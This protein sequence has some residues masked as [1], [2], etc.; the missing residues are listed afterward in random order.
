MD[1]PP[2]YKIFTC[3]FYKEDFFKIVWGSV[4]KLKYLLYSLFVIFLLSALNACS[5]SNTK[6]AGDKKV[7]DY[8]SDGSVASLSV[9]PD[10][11]LPEEKTDVDIAALIKKNS[12]ENVAIAS[13]NLQ[14]KKSGNRRYLVISQ[15]VDIVWNV[16]EGFFKQSGFVIENSRPE[17]GIMT[18]NYLKR[19]I[20]VPAKQLN[21]VRASLQKFLETS[22]VLPILDRYRAR[23]EPI[24]ATSSAI[25]LT[26]NTLE[27][28]PTESKVTESE[29]TIWRL[30]ERDIEQETEM[31]YRLMTY[32]GSDEVKARS[33]IDAASEELAL[34]I[35][36]ITKPNGASALN[37]KQNKEEVWRYVSWALDSLNI[38]V[39]DKDLQEGTFYIDANITSKKKGW[40]ARLF[41]TSD[42]H[43]FQILVRQ[44]G[45]D[46]TEVSL[47]ELSDESQ[48]QMIRFSEEFLTKLAHQLSGKNAQ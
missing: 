34:E 32:L 13:K 43:S 8:E 44:M 30:R 2:W 37:F 36:F 3:A 23:L 42:V 19:T 48:T 27:E 9:P 28:L 12:Q 10:L 31:L 46:I 5:S 11:S 18:T 16:V 26:I 17:L 7:F 15:S 22:Y 1:N 47:N 39:E 40:F 29:N 35:D 33:K 41:D 14:V 6:K 25:Y 20:E 4:K 45:H 24:N 38:D 21:I